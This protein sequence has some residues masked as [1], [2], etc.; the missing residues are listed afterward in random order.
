MTVEAGSDT[1]HHDGGGEEQEG[2]N[3][4]DQDDQ[5]MVEVRPEPGINHNMYKSESY[6]HSHLASGSEK[7][8]PSWNQSISLV[9][10]IHE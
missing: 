2:G 5:R 3:N 4:T 1:G 7:S 8:L 6:H 10:S 9:G